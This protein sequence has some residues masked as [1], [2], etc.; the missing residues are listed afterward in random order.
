MARW[1]IA[2][3]MSE[4]PYA[5]IIPPDQHDPVAAAKLV[6]LMLEHGVEV[7]EATEPLHVGLLGLPGG[8]DGDPCGAAVP[9]VSC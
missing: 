9:A 6:D 5:W 8:H 7:A 3:G 1:S 4:P 2:N